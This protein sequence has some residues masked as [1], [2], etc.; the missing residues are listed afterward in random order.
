[1]KDYVEL[2][3]VAERLYRLFLDIVK[4][5]LQ[6]LGIKDLNN[7]Q[8]LILYHIGRETVTIS[9][10]TSRRYY[11]GSNV[12]YNLRKMTEYGY[13]EQVRSEYDRRTI[14]INLSEK[15]IDLLDKIEV[16]FSKQLGLLH[17]HG[18]KDA[19]IQDL[20]SSIVMIEKVLTDLR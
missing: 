4:V 10:I 13:I 3:L 9:D 12:S 17:S 11:V 20:R 6:K 7:I 5:E 1:M 8:S 2:I 14:Y 19:Q 16:I 18:M 15:G